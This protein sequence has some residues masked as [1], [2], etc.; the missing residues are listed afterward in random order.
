MICPT[1]AKFEQNYN[2]PQV[3]VFL[4]IGMLFSMLHNELPQI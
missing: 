1:E 3:V 4:P 2:I